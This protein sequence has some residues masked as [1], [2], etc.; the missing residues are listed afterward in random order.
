[1]L[2]RL[3]KSVADAKFLDENH[4]ITISTNKAKAHTYTMLKSSLKSYP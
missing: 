4:N 2:D 1:M 3:I